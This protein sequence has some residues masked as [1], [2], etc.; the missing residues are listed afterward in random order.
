V[1]AEDWRYQWSRRVAA[2]GVALLLIGA[3]WVLP[4]HRS[5]QASLALKA[6]Q[7]AQRVLSEGHQQKAEETWRAGLLARGDHGPP[8]VVP[9]LLR[10]EPSDG[11]VI[12][13]NTTQ[14][15]LVVALAKVM[16]AAGAPGGWRACAMHTDGGSG[17]TLRFYSVSLNP[18]AHAT[19]VT[20]ESCPEAF[21]NAP[22]E[23]RV[24]RYPSETG[25]WSDS[26]FAAPK[27]REY[28]DGK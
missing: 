20:I 12:I 10:A 7:S 15:P 9:P 5:G 21:R 18:G 24:G 2:S 8:G 11:G 6:E 4:A 26:A 3:L 17:G 23:Y 14:R 25:W 13:T 1:I 28:A 19:F 22:I 27:G 16:E